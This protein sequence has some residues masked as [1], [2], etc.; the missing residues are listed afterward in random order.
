[1]QS[2]AQ[3]MKHDTDEEHSYYRDPEKDETKKALAEKGELK[4]LRSH[5]VI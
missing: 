2:T 5:R 1:M 4:I 3:D